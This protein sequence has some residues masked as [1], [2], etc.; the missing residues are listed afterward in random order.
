M[1]EKQDIIK[2]YDEAS[3]VGKQ[4]ALATVVHVEGSSYRRPGARMLVTEKGEL[5]GAIS[6]GCLE[7]DALRKALLVMSDNRAR[8]VTYDTMDDDDA[9]LG[10][11]LGCNG[12]IQILIEP[13]D[14]TKQDNPIQLLKKMVSDRKK[15]IIT[16]LFS[17][18]DRWGVQIGTCMF[19]NDNEMTGGNFEDEV[20][21]SALVNDVKSALQNEESSTRNYVSDKT[22]ITAF[23]ELINP[24]VSLVIVGAGNDAMPLVKMGDILGWNVTVMDGRPDYASAQRFASSC[25]IVVTKPEKALS[26]IEIDGQTVFVLMTHNYNYDY[27][28]L[29]QLVLEKTNYIGVL[30]PKK[31]LDRIFDEM[32]NEG[33][34]LTEEQLSKIYGPVGLDIGAEAPEEIG[35]SII[36]EIKA[37]LAA[38]AGNSLRNHSETIHPRSNQ[39]IERVSLH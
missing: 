27:A 21:K 34:V 26:K 14:P 17:L 9:K 19:Y 2:S 5:T 1:K 22:D 36:A 25:Q 28:M 7:G 37:V 16:T 18:Q 31:K 3:A 11:G 24:V 23:L 35:L 10:V 6:G 29:K 32:K 39:E 4:T 20:L 38:R 30:G 33:I 8:L 15:S 13:I 12:I